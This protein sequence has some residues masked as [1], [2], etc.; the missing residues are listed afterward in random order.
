MHPTETRATMTITGIGIGSSLDR[1]GP[2]CQTGGV[3]ELPDLV[4]VEEELSRALTG[5]LISGARTGD[6]L[7][8]RVMVTEPFPSVLTGRHLIEVRRRGHFMR[9]ALEGDLVIVVNAMLAG[10]YRLVTRPPGT[11]RAKDPRALGLALE[12]EGAPELQYVDEKRMGKVYVARAADE[13]QIPVYGQLGLDVLSPAFTRE[14]FGRLLARRRDQARMFLMDKRALASIGN[15]YADEILFAARIHPKTFCPKLSP[16]EADAL[17]AAIPRVLE[18][19]I[20]EIRRRREPVDVKVRDFLA[21][22]G[23]DGK[24][25]RVCGTT[26]RA[27]RV[28]DGDACFCPTCQPATRKLFVDWARVPP[29]G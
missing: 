9:F 26:I 4:Y 3:P 15:A 14:A 20:A 27:V 13:A 10:R 6:P 23:R 19:A 7:V 2:E 1:P 25:C 21:V 28:G 17:H 29:R 18:E 12:M 11:A 22:R 16:A 24:P 5:R 8:L